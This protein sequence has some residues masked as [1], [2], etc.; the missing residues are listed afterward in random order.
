VKP[1][2][3][4]ELDLLVLRAGR[5]IVITKRY[6]GKQP[7]QACSAA[8]MTKGIVKVLQVRE[9]EEDRTGGQHADVD[10]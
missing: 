10:R 7:A 9:V 2:Q 6:R 1:S 8:S 4:Y 3:L 5:E